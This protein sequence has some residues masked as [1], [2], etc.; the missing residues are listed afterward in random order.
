MSKKKSKS[1][2]VTYENR[3]SEV[4]RGHLLSVPLAEKCILRHHELKHLIPKK[5]MVTMEID[6]TS[7]VREFVD[8]YAKALKVSRDAVIVAVLL[9]QLEK[10][11]DVE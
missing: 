1:K 3:I 6:L 2:A 5:S 9:S 4:A 7:D 11:P 8:T 10:F